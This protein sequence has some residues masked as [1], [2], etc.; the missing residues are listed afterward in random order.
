[1]DKYNNERMINV[2]R[3]KNHRLFKLSSK[4]K[5]PYTKIGWEAFLLKCTEIKNKWMTL[6][7][8]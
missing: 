8:Y 5:K 7:L 6:P 4:K 2:K 3:D 1:M